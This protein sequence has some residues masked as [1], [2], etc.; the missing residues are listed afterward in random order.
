MMVRFY[1]YFI[2][3]F[4]PEILFGQKIELFVFYI[5]VNSFFDF[6]VCYACAYVAL[7]CVMA[8]FF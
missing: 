4:P 5:A 2:F 7:T 1:F 6:A 8:A 3:L